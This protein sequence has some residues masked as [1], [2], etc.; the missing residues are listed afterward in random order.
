MKLRFLLALVALSV[1]SGCRSMKVTIE[2]GE[3]YNFAALKTF[4]WIDGPEEILD[5][6][7]TYININIQKALNTQLIKLGLKQVLNAAEAD[8]QVAYYVKLR[9]QE[10]YAS[11]SNRDE[12]DFS[13]GFVYS[14]DSKSWAYKERESDLTVYAV[15]IGTL[16]VLLYNADTGDR[17]WRGNLKTHIDRSHPEEQR[18]NLINDAAEKLIGRLPVAN[19]QP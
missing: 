7:D 15:E 1:L 3:E 9:E 4:Q 13:G 14:R 2:Q 6:A 16:T 10:E 17:I 12:S 5:D 19:P 8:I 11:N 18:R